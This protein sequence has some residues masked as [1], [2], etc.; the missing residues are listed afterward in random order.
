MNY[1]K[2]MYNTR[3]KK[4]ERSLYVKLTS[5]QVRLH[6]E[7]IERYII[8]IVNKLYNF[9]TRESLFDFIIDKNKNINEFN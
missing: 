3:I 7:K 1:I 8:P 4:V 5:T 2:F 6:G 9:N